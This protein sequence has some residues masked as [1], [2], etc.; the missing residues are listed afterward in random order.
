MKQS[1]IELSA[2]LTGLSRVELLGTGL[3]DEYWSVVVAEVGQ[4]TADQL[5]NKWQQV[6]RSSLPMPTALRQELLGDPRLG[7]LG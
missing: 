6:Q 1:F 5:L 4:E 7:P 3:A 2:T